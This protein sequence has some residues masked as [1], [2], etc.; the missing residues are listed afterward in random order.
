MNKSSDK[1]VAI[2][3]VFLAL[4]ISLTLLP[5]ASA[6][7]T[8]DRA[9]STYSDTAPYR[10]YMQYKM[11]C[12][13]YAVHIYYP[14]GSSYAPYKQQ[15]GEFDR[16]TEPYSD[17]MQSYEYAMTY[18]NNLYYFVAD[19]MFE[20]FYTLDG[21]EDEFDLVET[22]RTASV[23]AGQRKIALSIR[24]D[25]YNSDYHFYLRHSDGTWSHKPG[26]TAITDY[27][28]SGVKITDS[29]IAT[30]SQEN[31]YDDGTRYFLTDKSV[32]V[33]FPQD[34]GQYSYTLYA[35]VS[36]REK[37]G[38]SITKSFTIGNSWTSRFDYNRD[39]D[40]YKFTPSSSG[41][42]KISTDRGAG[43]DI[44]GAV[45]DSNG[46]VLVSDYSS[47]NADF[48]I[49]LNAGSTYYAFMDDYNGNTG[50]YIFWYYKI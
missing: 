28:F 19:R 14:G 42:Y 6:A 23:P 44:D 15:P 16:N 33:D 34:Y 9:A 4:S 5:S 3:A 38:D 49:Y 30:V 24:Q 8:I 17:L 21:Y 10:S 43:Y 29:N 36:F 32:V 41:T 13:G 20:D 31:G 35:T 22:T 26:S 27:S 50:E 12:Y 1:Y 2:F 39:K 40:F 7:I 25:G 37:A 45:F 46:N 18:W 11:N 48:S 47:N